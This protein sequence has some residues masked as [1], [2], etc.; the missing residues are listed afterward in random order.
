[1]ITGTYLSSNDRRS[2]VTLEGQCLGIKFTRY[3]ERIPLNYVI[4]DKSNKLF[5]KAV[6]R[7]RIQ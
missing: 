5:S 1:M 3:W 4:K 6:F 2:K 7:I